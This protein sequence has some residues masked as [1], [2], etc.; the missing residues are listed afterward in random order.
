VF[1]NT[2]VIFSASERA[3]ETYVRPNCKVGVS[4]GSG[5]V[6]GKA[7]WRQMQNQGRERKGKD[8]KEKWKVIPH[9]LSVWAKDLSTKALPMNLR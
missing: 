6:T 2:S 8:T 4:S 5:E 1:A 9:V 3:T 7:D